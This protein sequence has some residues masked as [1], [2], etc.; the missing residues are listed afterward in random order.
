MTSRIVKF[1][2]PDR[3]G[4]LAEVSAIFAANRC[5]LT[6]VN[7]YTDMEAGWFFARFEF[8]PPNLAPPSECPVSEEI[9]ALA[10]SVGGEWTS[11]PKSLRRKLAILCSRDGHCLADL[12][13][14]WRSGSL[15]FDLVG[16]LSN[17]GQLGSVVEREG[18]PFA[19][20]PV[21]VD[22]DASF[23]SVSSTV[24]SWGAE[25]IVLA[26]YMQILPPWLCREWENRA[27]NIH[28]SFLPAF[29]GASPYLQAY[30]KGVKIIG[31]TCHYVTAELDAGPIIEQEVLRVSHFHGPEDLV[32]AG[33]DCE[34]MALS[35][36]LLYHLE[37]RVF[38]HRGKTVVFSG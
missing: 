26:R 25:V 21:G 24:S 11:R 34:R 37:D 38:C 17:H 1:S 20:I 10:K 18:V 35:R 23:R 27:I 7:Q 15:P 13:W 2:C 12:L 31:A 8:E 14:R 4:L 9:A 19:V 36:G 28:H 6:E 33:Q 32:H 5:N 3:V 29:P 16:V 22:R 30:K